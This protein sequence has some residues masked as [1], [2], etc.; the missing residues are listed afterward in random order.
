MNANALVFMLGGSDTTITSV[1]GCLYL[2]L[3]NPDKLEKLT[4][5]VRS[6]FATDADITLDA[7]NRLPYLV[8]VLS[9]AMRMYPPVTANLV[10]ETPRGGGLIAGKLVAENVGALLFVCLQRA[11]VFDGII[12]MLTC[13]DDQ[14]M[15]EVQQWSIHH[16]KEHWTEPWTFRPERFLEKDSTKDNLSALQPFSNGPRQC[17]GRK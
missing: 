11:G 4:Q 5:D 7:V 6:A 8:A 3:S 13:S 12:V 14:T 10:R 9:E 2:L 1:S 15:V 17:L 16:S